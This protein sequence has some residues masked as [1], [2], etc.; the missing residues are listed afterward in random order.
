MQF[1]FSLSQKVWEW[2][3]A[4]TQRDVDTHTHLPF[5]QNIAFHSLL[6][7]FTRNKHRLL[8]LALPFHSFPTFHLLALLSSPPL[9]LST[10]PAQITD[11]Q[12][13]T[14]KLLSFAISLPVSFS[15]PS[16]HT[17]THALSGSSPTSTPQETALRPPY[18]LLP[19]SLSLFASPN[20]SWPCRQSRLISPPLCQCWDLK[21]QT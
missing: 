2:S 11:T 1:N 16:P 12:I 18:S 4:L 17:C 21:S 15:L 10:A 5:R 3:L 19:L 9:P 14:Y 7:L 20:V 6:R 8:P 13:L